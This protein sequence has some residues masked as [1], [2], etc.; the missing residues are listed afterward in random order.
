MSR[1]SKEGTSVFWVDLAIL[2]TASTFAHEGN[3]E[4]AFLDVSPSSYWGVLIPNEG[5]RIFR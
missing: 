3:L 5:K 4:G 1:K 2:A